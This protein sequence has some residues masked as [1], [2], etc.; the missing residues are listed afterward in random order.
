MDSVDKREML[1]LKS[2]KTEF[3]EPPCIYF[4]DFLLAHVALDVADSHA[5]SRA[6]RV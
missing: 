1:R 5:S 3:L 6:R 4:C 2:R